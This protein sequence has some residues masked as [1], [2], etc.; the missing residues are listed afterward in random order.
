MENNKCAKEHCKEPKFKTYDLCAACFVKKHR[1]QCDE[2]GCSIYQH[3]E[4][5]YKEANEVAVT[6]YYEGDSNL[7]VLYDELTY[8]TNIN[9]HFSVQDVYDYEDWGAEL[10]RRFNAIEKER[11]ELQ[12]E[13]D[14]LLEELNALTNR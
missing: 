2:D 9:K 7:D 10:E 14:A 1:L 5:D 8:L 12:E 3:L 4:G 6:N 11:D 13:R